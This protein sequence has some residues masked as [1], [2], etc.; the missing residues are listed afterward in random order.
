MIVNSSLFA[1]IILLALG[2]LICFRGLSLYK[3]VQF[4]ICAWLGMTVAMWGLGKLNVD[5]TG[6][7]EWIW[8]VVPLAVG[9]TAGIVGFR[10][11][12]VGIYLTA[13]AASFFIVF[14]FFWRK[15]LSVGRELMNQISSIDEVFSLSN[16]LKTFLSGKEFGQE[17]SLL[18]AMLAENGIQPA[19]WSLEIEQISIYLKQGIMWAGLIGIAC[20]IL[21]LLF[22][23]YVIM[24]VTAVFGAMILNFLVEM[25]LP[26]NPT[27]SMAVMAALSVLGFFLQWQRKKGK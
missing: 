10:K 4:I 12:K 21:A 13:F 16:M 8:I 6:A 9:L 18:E 23:D 11:Y 1:G 7:L 2:G 20:G 24:S 5:R 19:V 25:Y 27:A 22:G 26:L 17:K 15:A 14:S 3:L